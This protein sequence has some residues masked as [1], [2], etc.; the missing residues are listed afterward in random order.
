MDTSIKIRYCHNS[1]LDLFW[2]GNYF[3]CLE[4]GEAVIRTYLDRLEER[5]EE[6]FIL[7]TAIFAEY[8][9]ARNP[10]YLRMARRLIEQ[11]RLQIGAAYVDINEHL[12]P[13]ESHIRNLALGKAWYRVV[14][15]TIANGGRSAQAEPD[16][17]GISSRLGA[18]RRRRRDL[19]DLCAT[20]IDPERGQC[21]DHRD[22]RQTP[23]RGANG[24]G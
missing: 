6:T 4:R 8:F 18:I 11:K 12:S 2:L 1:H 10:G 15:V 24:H 14:T 23:G 7:E 9:F 17:G 19:R 5:E 20:S 3:S 16:A 13:G 22:R 21:N